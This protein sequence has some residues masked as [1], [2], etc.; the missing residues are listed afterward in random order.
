[1][2]TI[3]ITK[4]AL[5]RFLRDRSNIFFVFIMPLAMV[6]LI[7]TQYSSGMVSTIGVY[8]EGDS[9]LGS[10]II[11]NLEVASEF[12]AVSSETGEERV[13]QLFKLEEFDELDDL[14]R[15]V[16][17]GHAVLGVSI[18][19][20]L[21]ETVLSGETA[22]IGT[23]VR[24]LGYGPQYL[25]TVDEAV[26]AAQNELLAIRFAVSKGADESIALELVPELVSGMK[27][28]SV[29][30]TSQ[31]ESL[32]PSSMGQ[33]D[34]GSHT[35][36]VLWMFL[37]GLEGSARIIQA[38]RLGVA[39]RMLGTPTS[40]GTIVTGEAFGRLAIVVFQGLYIIIATALVFQVDWGNWLGTAAVVVVFG[41]VAAASAMLLGGLFRNDEQAGGVSI[42][43]AMGLAALGGC[44]MPIEFF[45]AGMLKVAKLTPHYWANDS[46][47]ELVR[48]N[49]TIVDILPNL[50]ILLATAV[51][52]GVVATWAMRRALTR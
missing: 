6:L 11:E 5:L 8:I 40:V 9:E 16:E 36:T 39:R 48:H 30:T 46:L 49:G 4:T 20:G 35:M 47:A 28:I 37:S 43:L 1:M 42:L 31:G 14:I 45:P 26:F 41:L 3:A 12:R 21:D 13:T 15:A 10:Q 44:M 18:P 34:L 52:I 22:E 25:A 50:G 7:G 29:A 33:F 24:S 19:S 17:K 23:I 2:K 38:R 27:E 51:S 32:F